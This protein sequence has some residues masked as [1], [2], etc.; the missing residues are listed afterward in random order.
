MAHI[1]TLST[2]REW[3]ND[4]IAGTDLVFVSSK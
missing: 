2:S 1:N 4:M 3:K